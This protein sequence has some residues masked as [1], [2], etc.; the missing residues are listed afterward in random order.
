MGAILITDAVEAQWGA[1][2]TQAAPGPGSSA[3]REP[4]AAMLWVLTGG[5][6]AAMLS[7]WHWPAHRAQFPDFIALFESVERALASS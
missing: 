7:L 4:W 2:I 6:A 1:A 5:G 3:W